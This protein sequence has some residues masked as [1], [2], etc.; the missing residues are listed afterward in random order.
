MRV[1]LFVDAYIPE[2]NVLIEQKSLGID[3]AK[4]AHQS[5]AIDLTPYEQG[6]YEAELGRNERLE[7]IMKKYK[8]SAAIRYD[9]NG[10]RIQ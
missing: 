4:K 1:G 7:K 9:K 5:G 3:L 6:V 8:N 2:T 10:E